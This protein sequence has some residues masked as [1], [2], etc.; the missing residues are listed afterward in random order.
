MSCQVGLRSRFIF[1]E[2]EEIPEFLLLGLFYYSLRDE[3]FILI[4]NQVCGPDV[5]GPLKI[6]LLLTFCGNH[7]TLWLLTN[8]V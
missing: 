2:H 6:L 4:S 5:G 1:V 8:T 3:S 7:F